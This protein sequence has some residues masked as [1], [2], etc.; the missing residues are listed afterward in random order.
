MI[1]PLFP[2]T[3]LLCLFASA[4]GTEWDDLRAQYQTCTVLGGLGAASGDFNPNEW[5]NAEGLSALAAELS[6]PHMAMADIHGRVF[7]ADKNAHAIRR[8]DLD[9]TIHTVAGMNLGELPGINSGFNGDGDARECL[10]NGPQNAYVLPDGT[11]Y[12]LDSVNMRVRRVDTAGNLTTVITDTVNLNRGLWVRRDEQVIYYSTFNQ[13]KRWT[14]S[15]G[16]GPGVVIAGGFPETGNLD[17]DAAGNIYISDRTNNAVY[18]VPPGYGGGA[19]T[20]VLRVAGL[21]GG[22]TLDSGSSSNGLPATQVG[23]RGVRGVAFHPLG[24]YFVATHRG[25]DVWYIDSGGRAWLFVE[26][27]NGNAHNPNPV[28]VPTSGIVMSEPRAV[29]VSLAGDVII[30]CNDAGFIRIV[31]S[32]LPPPAA[33][34]WEQQTWLP[35]AGMKLRWQST[36]GRWYFLERSSDLNPSFWSPLATLSSS[37]TFTEFTDSAALT[38]RRAFYRLRSFRSWPN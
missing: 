32:V 3:A 38:S 25:G 12:I 11:F 34:I 8:I 33:P 9:G 27:D 31:R 37:G 4:R 35:G 19:F 1:R 7:V 30:T 23:L 20:D 26:G 17:L 5:N 13:L 16:N 15:L 24:G 6:E 14:P 28:A 18:R 21:G 22:N 36:A 2:L 10:L 29:T